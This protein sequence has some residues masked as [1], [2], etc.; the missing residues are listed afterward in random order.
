MQRWNI[1]QVPIAFNNQPDKTYE[2]S[3]ANRVWVAGSDRGDA[4]LKRMV[5][6]LVVV[7]L[8]VVLVLSW[9][10]SLLA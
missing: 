8:A 1:D 10:M 4:D 7:V 2:N 9:L 5:V 6:V 3:G